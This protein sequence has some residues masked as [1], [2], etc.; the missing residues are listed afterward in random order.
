MQIGLALLCDIQ[1]ELERIDTCL[2]LRCTECHKIQ[3]RPQCAGRAATQ[4][5]F[6]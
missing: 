1:D 4:M 2:D 5:A 3:V 6:L